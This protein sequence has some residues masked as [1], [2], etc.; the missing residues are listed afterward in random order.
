MDENEEKEKLPPLM[1]FADI[2]CLVEP[3]EEGNKQ[4]VA[5]LICYA[6]GEDGPNVSHTFSGDTCIEQF[7]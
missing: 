6:T 3:I 5:D 7:I 4:F 2:E 1:V